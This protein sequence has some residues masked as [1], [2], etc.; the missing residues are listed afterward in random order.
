MRASSGN[1]VHGSSR[2]EAGVRARREADRDARLFGERAEHLVLT[3]RVVARLVASGSSS[4]SLSSQGMALISSE[5]WVAPAVP[6]SRALLLDEH[7]GVAWRVPT[8]AADAG[9]NARLGE[10]RD[11]VLLELVA[12]GWVLVMRGAEQRP[13]RPL[14]QRCV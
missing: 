8:G 11:D 13:Q 3:A 2:R 6:E 5:N 9:F 12:P 1:W 14:P 4:E 10:D 7:S